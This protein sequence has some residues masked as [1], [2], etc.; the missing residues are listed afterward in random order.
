MNDKQN[1]WKLGVSCRQHGGHEGGCSL[2]ETLIVLPCR[3]ARNTWQKSVN[4]SEER[5]MKRSTRHDSELRTP[6]F[7]DELLAE[8]G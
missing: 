7:L 5:T 3:L 2:S 4:V 6:P 8:A 1:E